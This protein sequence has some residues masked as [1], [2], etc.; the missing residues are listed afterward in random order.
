MKLGKFQTESCTDEDGKLISFTIFI[1]ANLSKWFEL[2]RQILV[3]LPF[4]PFFVVFLFI[5][6]PIEL[7]SS[8][9]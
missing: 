1:R 4:D 3:C 9:F 7:F 2:E 6:S 5:K 8:L